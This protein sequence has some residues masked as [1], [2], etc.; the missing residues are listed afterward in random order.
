MS[1]HKET[2]SVKRLGTF[3]RTE[4]NDSFWLVINVIG[5]MFHLE[6]SHVLHIY[7]DEEVTK[8]EIY[9]FIPR[10]SDKTRV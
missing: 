5:I 6:S 1:G 7:I 10:T 9:L 3:T 2:R 4:G 8:D